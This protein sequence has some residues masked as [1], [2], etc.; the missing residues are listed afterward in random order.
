MEA[1]RIID[2]ILKYEPIVVP[3]TVAKSIARF[4][5]LAEERPEPLIIRL[6]RAAEVLGVTTRALTTSFRLAAQQQIISVDPLVIPRVAWVRAADLAQ[7]IVVVPPRNWRSCAVRDH[8]FVLLAARVAQAAPAVHS[9]S[10]GALFPVPPTLSRALARHA[11]LLSASERDRFVSI[12]SQWQSLSDTD[13]LII[14]TLRMGRSS[15]NAIAERLRLDREVVSS[16][17]RL[18]PQKAAYLLTIRDKRATVTL[19][20][21]AT[22]LEGR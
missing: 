2:S 4:L 1:E 17:I 8:P 13:F 3:K 10:L 14:A 20:R 5:R 12:S 7:A 9:R 18:L 16:A 15:I 11:G 19:K 21:H 22:S 6:S